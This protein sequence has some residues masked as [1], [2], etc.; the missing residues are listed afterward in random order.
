MQKT[1]FT[2]VLL[3]AA[4]C[5]VSSQNCQ[6]KILTNYTNFNQ[7]NPKCE[8]SDVDILIYPFDA[9]KTYTWNFSS[10]YTGNFVGFG[11]HEAFGYIFGALKTNSGWFTLTVSDSLG[12]TF[13]DSVYIAIRPIP[14]VLQTGQTFACL[15]ATTFVKA[16][17]LTSYNA[18]YTYSWDNGETTQKINVTHAGGYGPAP[19]VTVTNKF[20][21]YASN[22][23]A[24]FIGTLFPDDPTIVAATDTII[25]TNE[26]ATLIIT[27]P[28]TG[29]IY[30]WK[31]NG[32][33]IFGAKQQ[34][35]TTKNTGMYSLEVKNSNGCKSTS[36]SINV[37]V[38]N[39]TVTIS[40]T[41]PSLCNV[42]SV[43]LSSV[44]NSNVA[45]QWKRNNIDIPNTNIDAYEAKTDGRY[46]VIVTDNEG[47]TNFSNMIE[48]TGQNCRNGYFENSNS[49]KIMAALWQ[50]N[51]QISCTDVY[52][53]AHFLL[54]NTDGSLIM[55]NKISFSSTTI[56]LDNMAN[57][58]Y[59]LNVTNGVT[60]SVFKLVVLNGENTIHSSR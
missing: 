31:K 28:L 45:Y 36:Q 53:N 13:T 5:N 40:T 46:K 21:C 38:Q 15:G 27:Q 7:Y 56:N 14:F 9:N 17:D 59:L 35:L 12:C 26:A 22:T 54:H 10:N 19:S 39:P 51:L 47:C 2:I 18:P 57:G 3:F 11:P 8:G 44:T 20:G 48:V 42:D 55:R 25:C 58:M 6:V 23:T 34:S 60:T 33:N 32:A 29:Q 1:I 43:L 52:E 30:T 24:Q 49:N 4:I 50:N 16:M 37:Q 41:N